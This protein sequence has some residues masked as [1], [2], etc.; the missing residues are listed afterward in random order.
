MRYCPFLLKVLSVLILIQLVFIASCFAF[1]VSQAD[2]TVKD[3]TSQKFG[4]FHFDI[5]PDTAYLYLNNDFNN[6][7]ILTDGKKLRLPSGEHSLYIFGKE[8]SDKRIFLNLVE[9]ET[10]S[11]RLEKPK[12]R[13]IE[14]VNTMY[15]AYKWDA[16]L[17]LF[18]DEDTGISLPHSGQRSYGMLKAK[19][20][21]GSYRV[22]Y[23]S[24]TGRVTD[25]Y[26]EVNNHELRT[27]EVYFR[28][29]RGKAIFGGIV[30]GASQLYKRQTGKAALV[31]GVFGL[32]TG[33]AIHFDQK[34]GSEAEKFNTLLGQY[35]DA[36]NEQNALELGNQLD[37]LS[38]RISNH[39]RNRNIF[40]TA[41]IIVYLANIADAFR[42]PEMGFARKRP[43][44]PYRD[45][46]IDMQDD[47]VVATVQI[48]F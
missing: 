1:Q 27:E 8:L 40:R 41:A 47:G 12:S 16:N 33:L 23:K 43:F 11:I 29:N 15:A 9:E 18:S 35:Q 39:R 46:S 13:E 44:N 22:Q 6:P 7:I 45:F 2:S 26:V 38:G 32:S 21:P 14:L 10:H 17:M 30:P 37:M 4:Y 3:T 34:L 36:G 42:E 24:S 19:L 25:S 5:E 31:F 48:R 28:P 20:P